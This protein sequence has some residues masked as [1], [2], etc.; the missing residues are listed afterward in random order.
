ML[1]KSDYYAHGWTMPGRRTNTNERQGYQGSEKSKNIAGTGNYT[2]FFRELDT[3][4]PHWW[5]IDPKFKAWESPYVVMGGNPILLNDVLG[6]VA[7]WDVD[8][9][10]GT[11]TYD[12]KDDGKVRVDGKEVISRN[13]KGNTIVSPGAKDE[14]LVNYTKYM[15]QFLKGRTIEN[16]SI[17]ENEKTLANNAQLSG[18]TISQNFIKNQAGMA[19]GYLYSRKT[20]SFEITRNCQGEI[21]FWYENPYDLL[22][23]LEHEFGHDEINKDMFVFF[24]EPLKMSDEQISITN[25]P[26]FLFPMKTKP[27]LARR[28]QT[29][30][31]GYIMEATFFKVNALIIALNIVGSEHEIRANKYE[32]KSPY[33]EKSS[34]R[35]KKFSEDYR[36]RNEQML[37]FWNTTINLYNRNTK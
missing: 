35:F 12:G 30:C 14:D 34:N 32:L 5:S 27:S 1:S 22:I 36:L 29:P 25:T 31:G 6:D 19:I 13:D 11:F 37:F 20:L 10:S 8:T 24:N 17:V 2:T 21:P 33:Y 7:G 23:N 4:N 28:T 16:V 9:K 15:M 18:E 3:R 26:G